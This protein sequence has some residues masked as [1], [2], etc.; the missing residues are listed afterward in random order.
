M[1]LGAGGR[2]PAALP[3]HIGADRKASLG[4]LSL[5]FFFFFLVLPTIGHFPYRHTRL[6]PP[7]AGY[8]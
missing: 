8:F 6:A 2:E 7:C 5:F 3:G 4:F 1:E